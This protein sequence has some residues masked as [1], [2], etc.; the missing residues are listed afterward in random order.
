VP[1]VPVLETKS[2]SSMQPIVMGSTF[3]IR[4]GSTPP[5]VG[6]PGKVGDMGDPIFMV[7]MSSR[8]WDFINGAW[9]E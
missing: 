8:V 2:M 4:D 1:K 6:L 9:R 3:L 7:V 5:K